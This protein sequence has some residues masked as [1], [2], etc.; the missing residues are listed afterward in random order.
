MLCN[1]RE[2]RVVWDEEWMVS[3][4]ENGRNPRLLVCAFRW[5]WR[6]SVLLETRVH[7]EWRA[8]LRRL[9]T[10]ISWKLLLKGTNI[11]GGGIW[12]ASTLRVTCMLFFLMHFL[13]FF[14]SLSRHREANWP[15]DSGPEEAPCAWLEED[16]QWLGWRLSRLCWEEWLYCPH[17]AAQI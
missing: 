9:E 1:G 6:T 11:C 12:L 10:F 3:L 14:P 5:H 2:L 8:S 17:R 4:S 13:F 7:K 15:E 16:P